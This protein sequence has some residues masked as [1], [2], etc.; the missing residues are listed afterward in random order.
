MFLWHSCVFPKVAAH[1]GSC[2]TWLQDANRAAPGSEL[3]SRRGGHWSRKCDRHWSGPCD[4]MQED[5]ASTDARDSFAVATSYHNSMRVHDCFFVSVLFWCRFGAFLLFSALLFRLYRCIGPYRMDCW[6]V[7]NAGLTEHVHRLDWLRLEELAF[8]RSSR[9]NDVYFIYLSLPKNYVV[10]DFAA[11]FD[12]TEL[13]ESISSMFHRFKLMAVSVD[14]VNHGQGAQSRQFGT[15]HEPLRHS[16]RPK[17]SVYPCKCSIWVKSGLASRVY[18]DRSTLASD[19]ADQRQNPDREHTRYW[20]CSVRYNLG[21]LTERHFVHGAF[22]IWLPVW[23]SHFGLVHGTNDVWKTTH[24]QCRI[25][26][27]RSVR[28]MKVESWVQ[29]VGVCL[30]KIKLRNWLDQ[31]YLVWLGTCYGAKMFGWHNENFCMAKEL[32]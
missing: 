24:D 28:S 29:L 19:W 22:A 21:K 23:L 1:E 31:T 7:N 6:C 26:D 20:K 17:P 10:I 27:V 15:S 2:W 16:H 4:M 5:W 12:P 9:P 32:G 25:W 30:I 13:I 8:G 3:Q 14:H 18:M 11:M